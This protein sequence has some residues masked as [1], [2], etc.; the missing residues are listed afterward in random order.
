VN[1]S[2]PHVNDT[3]ARLGVEIEQLGVDQI[4]RD[5]EV[6]ETPCGDGVWH[7]KR[8]PYMS[9]VQCSMLQKSTKHSCV[10]RTIAKPTFI[11]VLALI[12]SRLWA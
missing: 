3:I 2:H 12:Y 9:H 1:F 10:A 7:V 6:F 5:V 11:G 4:Q 8:C